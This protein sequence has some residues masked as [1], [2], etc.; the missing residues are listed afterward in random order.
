MS[1]SAFCQSFF[2]GYHHP[3]AQHFFVFAVAAPVAKNELYCV[4][5]LSAMIAHHAMFLVRGFWVASYVVVGV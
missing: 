2:D 5:D 4:V 3:L 1:P